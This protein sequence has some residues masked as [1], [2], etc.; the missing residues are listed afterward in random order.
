MNGFGGMKVRPLVLSDVP[1]LGWLP[2]P[3]GR[4][5]A[6]VCAG[7][8][9]STEGGPSGTLGCFVTDGESLFFVTASHVLGGLKGAGQDA[10]VYQSA[11]R[12]RAAGARPIGRVE[13]LTNAVGDAGY[14]HFEHNTDV[15]LVRM[16][17]GIDWDARVRGVG[18]PKGSA[19]RSG[20]RG[21]FRGS[22][23]GQATGLSASTSKSWGSNVSHWARDPESGEMLL[24]WENMAF[25][26]R[27]PGD[28]GYRRFGGPGDSG[29]IVWDRDRRAV[30][31]IVAC[32]P[33]EVFVTPW[34]RIERFTGKRVLAQAG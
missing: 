24:Y 10:D 25:F 34:D 22:K 8:S 32:G 9:V 31:M 30:G 3:R 11:R 33:R 27:S 26:G 4:V 29:S 18:L 28:R 20:T 12:Y 17:D 23:F 5:F 13:R 15:A 14:R 21:R 6:Q 7:C 1:Q 16:L 2:G 19:M